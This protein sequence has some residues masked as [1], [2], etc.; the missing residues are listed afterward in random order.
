MTLPPIPEALLLD[1]G[2]T[3]VF[4]DHAAV[5]H[6]LAQ[7]G[8]RVPPARLLRG[9]GRAKRQY[10]GFLRGGGS[11]EAGWFQLVAGMLR[12][13][14]APPERVDPL[15]RRLREVHDELNLWRRVPEGLPE[16]LERARRAGIRLAVVSNSE[17]KLPALFERVGLAG[18]FEA[19][20][21]SSLEGV[22]KPDPEIFR[23]ALGRLDVRAEQACYAGDLPEVDVEGARAV[24]MHAVLVDPFGFYD[25]YT[26]AP[27][28]S[29]VAELVRTW[30]EG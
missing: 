25:D 21:D 28:V 30:L 9:E 14:G 26:G 11:H 18:L 20:V 27:R 29:G 3:L 8:V 12:E 6:V 24:G 22:R 19:V 17:G 7:E 1:A 5:S 23:R 16:A 4:L 2:N 13:A 15:T 10:T